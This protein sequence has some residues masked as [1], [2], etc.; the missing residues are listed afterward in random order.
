MRGL[1][2]VY[3]GNITVMRRTH[4]VPGAGKVLVRRSWHDVKDN[5]LKNGSCPQVRALRYSGRVWERN[6]TV[7][8]PFEGLRISACGRAIVASW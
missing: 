6:I 3:E 4:I 1:H 5:Q 7:A 8:H 2:F